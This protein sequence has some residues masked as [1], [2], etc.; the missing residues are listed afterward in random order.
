MWPTLKVSGTPCKC[1]KYLL[2]SYLSISSPDD[3][4]LHFPAL[5]LDGSDLVIGI[6]VLL[7]LEL[8]PVLVP[9]PVRFGLV[10]RRTSRE[11]LY[12]P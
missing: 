4:T 5:L 11:T 6:Y 9:F 7:L 2:I 10:V 3:R 8:L 12:Y 1:V